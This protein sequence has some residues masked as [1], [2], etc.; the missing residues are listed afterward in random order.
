MASSILVGTG[1]G[2]L[3]NAYGQEPLYARNFA[4]KGPEAR[5]YFACVGGILFAVGCF[6]F[7]WSVCIQPSQHRRVDLE[8]MLSSLRFF[9]V[10]LRTSFPDV[11]FIAPC[12]GLTILSWGIFHICELTSLASH[13]LAYRLADVGSCSFRSQRFQLSGSSSLPLHLVHQMVSRFREG[14]R[15]S[16]LTDQSLALSFFRPT[17]ISSMPPPPWLASLSSGIC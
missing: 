3:A 15:A 14:R 12:I 5:L 11:H 6:I 2:G 8:L 7:A 4:R 9:S 13:L 16:E 17:P 10:S 1:L